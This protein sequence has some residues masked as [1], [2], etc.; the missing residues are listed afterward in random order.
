MT[1]Q[2]DGKIY[3]SWE[4]FHQDGKLLA[5]NIKAHGKTFNRIIAV[6]RG[7]IFIAGILAFE[8]FIRDVA[9]INVHS[10]NGENRTGNLKVSDLDDLYSDDQTLVVDDLT[11]TG[12]TFDLLREKFPKATFACV[13]TKPA[14]VASTDIAGKPMED[15]WIFF[16]WDVWVDGKVT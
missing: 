15:K 6:G 12:A 3:L 2:D 5:A 13:Y 7:G 1:Q 14:G 9:V 8:L 4:Q 11:D 16:P 10:Y